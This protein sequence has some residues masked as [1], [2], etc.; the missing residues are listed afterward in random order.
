MIMIN[1]IAVKLN[2]GRKLLRAA[3]AAASVMG[4]IG[5]M[6]TSAILA[7]GPVL[8]HF[9]FEAASVK[10]H[11][12]GDNQ[13]AYPNFSPD[14][15]FTSR[16]MPLVMVIGLA[17]GLPVQGG[18]ALRLIGGPSWI[19]SM[20]NTYDIEATAPKGAFPDGLSY[21]ARSE[22][23]RS[24]L[25]ALLAERFKFVIHHETKE[26]PVYALVVGKNGP[27]LPKADIDEKG[28]QEPAM[29]AR[30]LLSERLTPGAPAN[31][32]QQACHAI[33]GG[34]G[35]GLHGRAVNMGDL[36][37]RVEAWTDRPVLD[38]TGL[39]GL[40]KIDT[41]PWLPMELGATTPPPGA[42]QDG[43]DMADLPTL[44]MIFERLGLKMESQKARADVYL[45]DH[46]ERPAEN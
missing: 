2:T 30:D 41:G 21:A 32:G 46:V 14:G 7:Q 33:S 18:G 9:E 20:D 25:Q 42:K 43:V 3:A 37:S 26:M 40:Y 16:G 1:R 34:R 24:M 38:Q 4:P 15:R 6:D 8:Q 13:L 29:P 35:R 10:P 5:L 45:I 19:K 36:V 12:P 27:K 31:R 17:Y 23:M 44:F 22:R 39:K 28:C 11:K